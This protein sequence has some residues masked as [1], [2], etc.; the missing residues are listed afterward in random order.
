MTLQEARAILSPTHRRVL[1]TAF[2]ILERP[3]FAARLGD[4]AGRPVH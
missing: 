3:D 2:L 1:R 4:F